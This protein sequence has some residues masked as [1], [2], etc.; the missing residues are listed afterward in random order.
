MAN[1]AAW[2]LQTVRIKML[3]LFSKNSNV[4]STEFVRENY[5]GAINLRINLSIRLF[6]KIVFIG[7][8]PWSWYLDMII[9]VLKLK[10]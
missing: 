1:F 7:A 10:A 6:F 8:S 4:F 5:I 2:R 3:P 9:I